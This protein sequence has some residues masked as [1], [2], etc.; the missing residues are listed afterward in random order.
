VRSR[1]HVPLVFD[2]PAKFVRS[3]FADEASPL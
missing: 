3:G 2:D 1:G